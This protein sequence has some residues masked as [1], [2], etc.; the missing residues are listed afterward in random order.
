MTTREIIAANLRRVSERIAQAAQ[1][2]GRRPEEIKLIGVTKYV[3]ARR[4]RTLFEYGC[5]NL[6]E[7][8][9]QSLWE[10]AQA[11]VD[12]PVRWHMIGHLQRNKVKRTLPSIALLH[13]GDSLRLLQTVDE[14]AKLLSRTV[15]VLLE[16][17]ISGE[18]A[19]HGF[20]PDELSAVLP[21]IAMLSNVQVQGLMAMA[22]LEGGTIRAQQDF[23]ALRSLR[24]RLRRERPPQI[25]LEELSMGMSG[26]FQEAI[27]EGAT[28]IRVGSALWEGTGT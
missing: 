17:N 1:R 4:A 20:S 16:V 6:G 10:K 9:P 24:D 11:L 21:Q 25:S 26:D 19:K 7:S 23:A 15:E 8:R 18:A 13:S 3:D 5:A 27:Q 14:E 22:A 28:L 2:A 12:L